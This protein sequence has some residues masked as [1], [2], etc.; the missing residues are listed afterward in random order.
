[1]QREGIKPRRI[2]VA[3]SAVLTLKPHHFLDVLKLYGAG[4]RH[5]TPDKKYQ[6]DFYS[7]GNVILENPSVEITLT[8]GPDSMCLPCVFLQNR[9]CADILVDFA[10]TS[11]DDWNKTIDRRI[12]TV[13]NLD[14]GD[15]RTA[16]EL[17][18]L[19]RT[20]LTPEQIVKIWRERSN[21]ET[22]RRVSLLLTGLDEYSTRHA[23]SMPT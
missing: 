3:N 17:C 18:L 13:L 16:L 9:R 7:A 14:E 20:L 4:I 19:A 6:H 5:F 10:Y 2:Q 12:L 23:N 8:T 22:E 15:R 21:V 11:K 1:M